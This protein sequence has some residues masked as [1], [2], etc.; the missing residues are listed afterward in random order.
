M[1]STQNVGYSWYHSLQVR[2]EKRFS[3]GLNATLSYT[4]S[5]TMEALCA[6]STAPIRLWKK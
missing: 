6:T 3:H 5:K 2:V 1:S 4:W